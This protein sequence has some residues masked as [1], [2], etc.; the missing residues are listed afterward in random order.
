MEMDGA[1]KISPNIGTFFLL[2]GARISADEEKQFLVNTHGN[3]T[4]KIE[5]TLSLTF[6]D[7]ADK[8]KTKKTEHDFSPKRK[9]KSKQSSMKHPK[10]KRHA[11]DAESSQNSMLTQDTDEYFC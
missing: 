10:R 3:F 11:H 2:R 6:H 7:V 5:K 1:T 8:E 4:D 9:G